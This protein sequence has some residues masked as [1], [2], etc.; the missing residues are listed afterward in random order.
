MSK[1]QF[2]WY[3]PTKLD[4]TNDFVNHAPL[5]SHELYHTPHTSSLW[6][7]TAALSS[8]VSPSSPCHGGGKLE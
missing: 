3:H 2:Y 8:S 6:V 1:G 5:T 4:R 7:F